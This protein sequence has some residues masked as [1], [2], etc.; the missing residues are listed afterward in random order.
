MRLLFASA[1]CIFAVRC[2]DGANDHEPT[3]GTINDLF[4]DEDTNF[5]SEEYAAL[6]ERIREELA[7]D[8]VEL[9]NDV[10]KRLEKQVRCVH[11][12]YLHD[13]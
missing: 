2:D 9:F 4:T 7:D 6:K 10:T 11:I 12:I 5:H 3:G 8:V 1:L 13:S